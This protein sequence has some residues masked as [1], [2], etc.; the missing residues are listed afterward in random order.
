MPFKAVGR[1]GGTMTVGG[2]YSSAI[3]KND[4]CARIRANEEV[5]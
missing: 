3:E 1:R 4:G 2:E 5:A